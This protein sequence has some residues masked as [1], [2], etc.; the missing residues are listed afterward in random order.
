MDAQH[1]HTLMTDYVLGLLPPDERRRVESHARRCND[2]R[3]ALQREQAIGPLLRGAVMEAARPA[4]G[5]LAAIRP[6]L[7]APRSRPMPLYRRLAPVSLMAAMLVM[8][9]L[10]GSGRLAFSPALYAVP[11]TPT[12]TQTATYTHTPTATLAQAGA[13]DPLGTASPSAAQPVAAAIPSGDYP[14]P[15]ISQ[16]RPIATP[17]IQTAAP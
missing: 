4:P 2:C 11:D 13:A 10:F 9:L 3:L 14:P 16:P 15:A 12:H 7:P 6:P 17:I 1:T 8:A 5:R